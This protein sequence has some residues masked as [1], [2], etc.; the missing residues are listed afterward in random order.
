MC[1][2]HRDKSSCPQRSDIHRRYNESRLRENVVEDGIL[3]VI[4]R[5]IARLVRKWRPAAQSPVLLSSFALSS[6][7]CAQVPD[8]W[9]DA[10]RLALSWVEAV[11]AQLTLLADVRI[12]TKSSLDIVATAM[13]YRLRRFR[14]QN[15]LRENGRRM[16]CRHITSLWVLT[17]EPKIVDKSTIRVKSN[18]Q[19]CVRNRLRWTFTLER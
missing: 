5:C 3:K 4:Y 1:T 18:T 13:R 12:P 2:C 10:R 6:V 8:A 19:L 11:L 16:L 17:D 9:V 7:Q 15:M 14:G